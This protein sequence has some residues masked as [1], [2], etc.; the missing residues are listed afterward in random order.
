LMATSARR[1][2]LTGS[3]GDM[4]SDALMKVGPGYCVDFDCT[5]VFSARRLE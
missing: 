1:S 5:G 2:S 3:I 4:R